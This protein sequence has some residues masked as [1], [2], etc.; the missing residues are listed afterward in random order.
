MQDALSDVGSSFQ[1]Y[2]QKASALIGSRR[3]SQEAP[4]GSESS[5]KQLPS[6]ADDSEQPSDKEL[7]SS[8]SAKSEEASVTRSS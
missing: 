6:A 7:P 4:L 1:R 2:S 5:F 3:Q 8:S